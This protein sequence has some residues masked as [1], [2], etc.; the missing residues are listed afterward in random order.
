MRPA[1][2]QP[3]PQAHDIP[4]KTEAGRR[5][6]AG[7]RGGLPAGL[8]MLLILVDG[9]RGA[10]ELQALARG[11]GLDG[12]QALRMLAAEGLIAVPA[13]P[14]VVAQDD[15]DARRLVR[16]K[17]YALDLAARMLAGRDAALR[18]R[19]RAVDSESS[20]AAWLDDCAAEIGRVA[21][22][23]RAAAFRERVRAAAV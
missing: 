21:D 3:Q 18:E 1:M 4:S 23:E 13:S 20:F 2:P 8:R 17:F 14:A 10:A 22:A 6:L 5:L 9:R 7:P 12:P 11:I 15:S 16:A 19:A